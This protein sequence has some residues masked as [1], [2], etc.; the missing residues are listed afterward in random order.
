MTLNP[1]AHIAPLGLLM[2][3]FGPYGW[4]KPVQVRAANFTN[5][6]RLRVVLTSLSAPLANLLLG[7]IC[8]WL[9]FVV[10]AGFSGE[11]SLSLLL[12]GFLQ[13]SVI[14]NILYAII[15]LLPLYPLDGWYIVQAFFGKL[16]M[17]ESDASTSPKKNAWTMLGLFLTIAIL[18]TPFGQNLWSR[19]YL[20]V[21]GWIS[22]LL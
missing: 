17:Q 21:D 11:S 12:L 16:S 4:T 9:Y 3:L 13:Y 20:A 10:L 2:V 5:H 18:V 8:W 15:H 22:T 19:V 1:A 14:V 7:L 6:S